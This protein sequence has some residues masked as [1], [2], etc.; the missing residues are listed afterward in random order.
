MVSSPPSASE[1]LIGKLK[2]IM[3]VRLIFSTVLLGSTTILHFRESPSPVAAP[4][5]FL[6]GVIAGVFMLSL[7]YAVLVERLANLKPL[8][9]AQA[10]IDTVIVTVIIYITGSF[11][12]VFSFLYLLVIIYVNLLPYKKISLAMA[13]LCSLQYGLLIDLEYFGLL[14]PLD[15]NQYLTATRFVW[16]QVLFKVVITMAACFS[17]AVLGGLL[18]EQTRRHREQARAA[19]Q[20]AKRME[21]LASIGEMAAGLAH[22]IKNPLASLTGSI[23]MLKEDLPYDPIPEKLM[24][25][26]LRE[27]DR[28][29][30]LV[31]NFLLFARPP[32]GRPG[33][34]ELAGAVKGVLDLFQ[35]DCNCIGRI[36]L[37][38]RLVSGVWIE[39]D[40][41]HLHQV[42]WNL[43]INAAEAI[44]GEG[45]IEV[46]MAVRKSGAVELMIADSGSGIPA[47]VR[48]SIFDPF[49]TTKADGT[50]LGLSIVQRILDSYGAWLDYETREG[51]GTTFHLRFQS[52]QP[53]T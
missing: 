9:Y 43:L 39:M 23:Q 42:L 52:I 5:L 53:P 10:A 6:Y 40:P 28:L 25:I 47:D 19:E 22:E 31:N 48:A 16:N 1:E 49:F 29:G 34:L 44:S 38:R 51:S 36:T 18:A 50:G 32:A 27:A 24:Q 17:V 20:R 13:A 14:G 4:L 37:K 45:S 2:A 3:L 12:S 41:V 11:S 33:P 7:V 35:N 8:A 21:R 26:V 46:D 15:P 30:S